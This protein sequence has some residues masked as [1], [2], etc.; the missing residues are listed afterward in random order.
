MD[1]ERASTFWRRGDPRRGRLLA[2]GGAA[3]IVAI[4]SV[5]L[6]MAAGASASA[7]GG[8]VTGISGHTITIGLSAVESGPDAGVNSASQALE[9]YLKN[10][11]SRGGV[12][13]Y[14][15]KW[16]VE[17]NAFSASQSAVVARNLLSQ[18]P[19]LVNAVG[20][21]PVT[22]TI[23]V[24]ERMGVSTPLLLEGDG[25][26]IQEDVH[27]YPNLF[28]QNPNYRRLG[29]FDAQFVMT[30]LHMKDMA[31]AWEDDDLASGAAVA[32]KQY[33][34]AHG[35]KLLASIPIP[36]S[37]TNYNPIAAELK[38][39]GAKSVLLWSVSGF[40]AGIQKA[41]AAIGYAPKWITPFFS[42]TGSYLSIAGSAAQGTYIDGY[43]PPPVGSGGNISAFD[44]VV[45][46]SYPDAVNGIGEQGWEF[47]A[48]I[49]DAIKKATLDHKPLTTESF[50]DALKKMNGSRVDLM[51]VN[52]AS[53]RAG[54]VTSAMYQ[55]R[56]SS[57]VQVA[58]Q[59]KLPLP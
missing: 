47:G 31:L 33:V 39:S 49:T 6:G 24:A 50:V 21:V 27:R 42:L 55:V 9:A 30:H 54:A 5:G 13:G 53:S 38:A 2:V 36:D 52:Y 14:K 4:G 20:T 28:G 34:T 3:G 32:I 26:L 43:L 16:V 10:V 15:F 1:N 37:I 19:F 12:D 41:A 11:N 23:A 18:H 17:D 40:A 51:P 58:P 29:S 59:T 25:A 7:R 48:I 56:G 44:K 22:A 57:F 46:A 45:R 35:G 8:R